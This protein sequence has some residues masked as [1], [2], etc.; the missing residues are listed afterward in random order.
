M[1]STGKFFKKIREEKNL[2]VKETA[3]D[4]VTTQF[5]GKYESGNSDI[6]FTNLL[7]LLSR[8]NVTTEEFIAHITDNMDSWL[9]KIEQELDAAFNAGN[10]FLMKTFIEKQE[11]E[12]AE[13]ADKKY[14]YIADIGKKYYNY[15]FF[16]LYTVDLSEIRGYLRETEQWGKFELFLLTYSG[17]LF[18]S[19]EAFIYGKQLL[20]RKSTSVTINQWRCDG[21]LHII[22]QLI[23][24]NDLKRA[25]A[26]LDG[27]LTQISSD[28]EFYYLH[29]DLFARF[30]QGLFLIQKG[31]HKGKE[32]CEKIIDIFAD[33][34][35]YMDYANR[36]NTL[37]DYYGS[38]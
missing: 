35:G 26:L 14:K 33:T 31:E 11:E 22:L 10:S 12:F 29:Y 8:M 20:K 16:Q 13:T 34:L 36:L 5:L 15:I 24:V 37:Y 19:E 17:Q 9:L 4:I 27:Y 1:E 23:R 25:K 6:R 21:V 2:S 7:Q 30:V 28:R 38:S 32:Q 18:E 3:E